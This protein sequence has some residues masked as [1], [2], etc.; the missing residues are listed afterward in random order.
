MRVLLVGPHWDTGQWIEYC[1][2]GLRD[3]GHDVRMHR[4]SQRLERP[5]GLWGRVQRRLK[6]PDRFNVARVFD[7]MR[8]D[9]LDVIR[10]AA[11]HRP[12]FTLVLKG[13]VLL[14]ETIERLR[15]LTSGPVVQWCG[16]DPGWFPNIT[17]AAHLYDRFYLA[18]PTYAPDLEP[19][20]VTAR[21]MPH[22]VHPAAWT[23]QDADAEPVDVI[24]VGDA[25]HNMGH[26]PANRSRVEILEAVARSGANLAVWGRGWEKLEPGYRVREA[27]RGLTL[28]PAAA[29][30]R[31]Y[32]SAKIVLNIHHA[33]M[34]EGPNMRTFEIPAAGAFQLT[35][36]K[37]RM[38]ELFEVGTELATYQDADDA[39]ASIERYLNDESARR[40]IAAAGK[41]RVERDH[42]YAVRMRQLIEDSR[43]G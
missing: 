7:A 20:G 26:L 23:G 39:A 42:T 41:R 28:L 15:N 16:D 24:F 40:A 27:H 36:F 13:E 31:A 30:A 32:R 43:H 14:P 6:G 19:R 5:I 3:A 1:A 4:Y 10:L 2:E 29:V 33:Q 18:D 22:A 25:R 38:P 34:R 35:D 37:A 11:R 17:A 21:F 9:N 12:E 8:M